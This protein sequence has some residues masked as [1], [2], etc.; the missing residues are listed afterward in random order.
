LNSSDEDDK[1]IDWRFNALFV[2]TQPHYEADHFFPRTQLVGQVPP[3]FGFKVG[4]LM[5]DT[6]LVLLCEFSSAVCCLQAH[7]LSLAWRV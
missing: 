7:V 3:P 4:A 5:Q 1:V 6:C 2:D